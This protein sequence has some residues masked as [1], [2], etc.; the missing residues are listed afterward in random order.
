MD[1]TDKVR[2]DRL[3]RAVA[4]QGCQLEKSRRRDPRAL[5]YGRYRITDLATGVVVAGGDTFGGYG[6]SLDEVERWIYRE[7]QRAGS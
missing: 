3:R 2:E 4:R 1:S 5:D 6:L 7:E